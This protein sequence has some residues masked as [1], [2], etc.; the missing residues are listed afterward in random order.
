MF[1]FLLGL[2]I[3]T[4]LNGVWQHKDPEK[5]PR[6]WSSTTENVW[7]KMDSVIFED[8]YT[9]DSV[10]YHTGDTAAIR[11]KPRKNVSDSNVQRD[12]LQ[13]DGL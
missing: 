6:Y 13:L 8:V 2:F 9:Y 11:N 4:L 1:E 10:R 3:T 5:I 7:H 12:T